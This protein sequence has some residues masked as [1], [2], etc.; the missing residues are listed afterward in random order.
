M[1]EHF[2]LATPLKEMVVEDKNTAPNPT[3]GKPNDEG[4]RLLARTI[5]RSG[6]D[7]AFDDRLGR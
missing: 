5:L 1:P 7:E 6:C 3:G 4:A 2:K